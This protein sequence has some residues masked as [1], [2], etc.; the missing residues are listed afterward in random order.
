L[1]LPDQ[2]KLLHQNTPLYIQLYLG[3]YLGLQIGFDQLSFVSQAF[4]IR[5]NY[6]Y[7]FHQYN[8]LNRLFKPEVNLAVYFHFISNLRHLG[9]TSCYSKKM[10]ILAYIL[11]FNF[12]GLSDISASEKTLKTLKL[13]SKLLLEGHVIK[14]SN[15]G[16]RDLM[17]TLANMSAFYNFNAE[18]I[19]ED[20]NTSPHFRYSLNAWVSGGREGA[21]GTFKAQLGIIHK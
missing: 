21:R 3:S 9:L 1:R 4:Q 2:Q 5:N 7:H 11:L 19:F 17:S 15:F 14:D 13:S 12:E 8:L 16:L 20:S 18:S 10:A 6:P